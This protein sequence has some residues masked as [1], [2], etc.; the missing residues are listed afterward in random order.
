MFNATA[1]TGLGN[2]TAVATM[3]L[4]IPATTFAGSY[5]STWTYSLV[6]GP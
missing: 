6:S 5:T 2:E 4:A 1:N 3:R